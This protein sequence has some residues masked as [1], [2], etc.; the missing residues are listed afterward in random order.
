MI[1]FIIFFVMILITISFIESIILPRI[2]FL[3]FRK[4]L[5]TWEIPNLNRKCFGIYRKYPE[6]I[7]IKCKHCPHFVGKD[8]RM[9]YYTNN[10]K[11]RSIWTGE[12]DDV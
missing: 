6:Y 10:K 9:E 5:K 1:W 11:R 8:I 3:C 12:E 4:Q 2:R 7:P